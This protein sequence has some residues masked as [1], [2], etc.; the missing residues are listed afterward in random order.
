M[1]HRDT[2][3]YA[4]VIITNNCRNSAA[5]QLVSER[6]GN[7]VMAYLD[8]LSRRSVMQ[9]QTDTAEALDNMEDT[10]RSMAVYRDGDDLRD[11]IRELNFTADGS[12]LN[13]KAPHSH[14]D[15]NERLHD[16]LLCYNQ[17]F[18][19][20]GF[21]NAKWLEKRNFYIEKPKGSPSRKSGSI[22]SQ[23][24]AT[25]PIPKPQKTF[26]SSIVSSTAA[27]LATH[28]H[29]S[30]RAP[31]KRRASIFNDRDENQLKVKDRS[32]FMYRSN[33]LVHWVKTQDKELQR[34]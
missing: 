12:R 3:A 19:P 8:T 32:V 15:I 2:L 11:K 23:R 18:I 14:A 9:L 33:R 10:R 20:I 21:Y 28:G 29:E 34:I 22:E 26:S 13:L 27:N 31:I 7:S 5:R 30:M 25:T 17:H 6:R 16:R 24:N 4:E 1:F